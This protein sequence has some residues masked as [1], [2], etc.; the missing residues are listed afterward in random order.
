MAQVS[1]GLVDDHQVVLLGM[2]ALFLGRKD[3]IKVVGIASNGDEALELAKDKDPDVM[4]LDYRMPGGSVDGFELTQRL[5]EEAPGTRLVLYT[6]VDEFKMAKRAMEAG[7]TAVVSKD[8]KNTDL[9]EATLMAAVNRPYVS[10]AF[11]AEAE[12]GEFRELSARQMTVLRHIANGLGTKEIAEQMNLSEETVRHHVKQV[13]ARLGASG[14]AHAVAIGLRN[15][16][17]N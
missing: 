10:P 5:R 14:R 7:V 6:G 1:V 3:D 11:A 13:T 17:L 12:S 9:V 8:D 15:A 2:H 16:L 4:C